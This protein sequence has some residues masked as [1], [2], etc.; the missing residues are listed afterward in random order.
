MQEA[1]LAVKRVVEID[2]DFGNAQEVIEGVMSGVGV[3]MLNL[4]AS[5]VDE[6]ENK[7]RMGMIW[8]WDIEDMELLLALRAV[9]QVKIDV[10]M[11]MVRERKE[12]E[13]EEREREEREEKESGGR[14]ESSSLLEGISSVSDS[15]LM[16]PED[17][18]I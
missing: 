4:L 7:K 11:I 8:R 15:V 5:D 13:R 1:I 18:T 16:A 10:A 9:L 3:E 12:R 17:G 14:K 2:K 6:K